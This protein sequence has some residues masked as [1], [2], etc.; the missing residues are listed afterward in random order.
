MI[1]DKEHKEQIAREPA[2]AA[3]KPIQ[4]CSLVQMLELIH[5]G[6]GGIRIPVSARLGI[7]MI[8]RYDVSARPEM[9]TT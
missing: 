4:K 3:A 9:V 1:R 8:S 7:F 5:G 2:S 6:E